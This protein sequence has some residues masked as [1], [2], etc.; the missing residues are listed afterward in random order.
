[1]LMDAMNA[2]GGGENGSDRQVR[3]R[4]TTKLPPQLRVTSAPF[5]VPAKLARYGLSELVR[6]SLEKLLINK[7]LSA[8]RTCHSHVDTHTHHNSPINPTQES[9]LTLEYVPAV[10]PPHKDAA[11]KHDDWVSAVHGRHNK[12]IITGS[13]N[14]N[15]RQ[16]TCVCVL[17]GHTDAVNDVVAVP[18]TS[19]NTLRGK[20]RCSCSKVPDDVATNASKTATKHTPVRVFKGHNAAVEAVASSPDG[21]LLCS[22]GWDMELKFWQANG[23]GSAEEGKAVSVDRSLAGHTQCVSALSWPSASRDTLY[24]S[25]WDHSLRAWDVETGSNTQTLTSSKAVYTLSVD[26]HARLVA[27]GGADTTVRVWDTRAR[28]STTPGI[29]L[30]SNGSEWV[31]AVRFSPSNAHQLIAASYDGSIRLWDVRG[32]VPLHTVSQ[33]HEGKALAVDWLGDGE[34]AFASGG[35]D[36]RMVVYTMSGVQQ[37]RTDA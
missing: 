14:A 27:T 12:L 30:S 6:T 17:Q 8:V 37:D 26:Q 7:Q 1:M 28:N 11:A 4:F 24:S 10:A 36:G 25:S 13:Y 16:G 21:R 15:A 34:T 32:K 23:A 19:A 5:A 33:A 3:V 2:G 9:I 35:E 29:R 18:T 22:G 31:S 20:S